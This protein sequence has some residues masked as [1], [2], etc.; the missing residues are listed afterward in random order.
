[1][2]GAS[3]PPQGPKVVQIGDQ[4]LVN[5]GPDPKELFSSFVG[6][7][8]YLAPEVVLNAGHNSSV[9]WW[10]YGILIYEMLYGFTPFKGANKSQTLKNITTL[11][12]KFPSEYKVSSTC[13]SLIRKP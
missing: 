1:M 7:I 10:G 9:D 2:L 6:T 4:H 13:K 12:V 11:T 3:L 8:E 5:T